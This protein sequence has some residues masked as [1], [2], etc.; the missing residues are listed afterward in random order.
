[1]LIVWISSSYSDIHSGQNLSTAG[2]L[3]DSFFWIFCAN[4]STL[5]VLLGSGW[6]LLFKDRFPE[7]NQCLCLQYPRK[8]SSAAVNW[9]LWCFSIR[10]FLNLVFSFHFQRHGMSTW[11][12]SL[13]FS[14]ILDIAFHLNIPSWGVFFQEATLKFSTV[15]VVA[16]VNLLCYCVLNTLHRMGIGIFDRE[17]SESLYMLTTAIW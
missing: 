6:V 9:Y 5:N 7:V 15:T 10:I 2:A 14:E 1:M 16:L 12:R 11:L 13:N 3:S 17:V 4:S 8:T